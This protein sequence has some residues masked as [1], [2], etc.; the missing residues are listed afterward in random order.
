MPPRDTNK[1][2]KFLAKIPTFEPTSSNKQQSTDYETLSWIERG[3]E[4]YL[5]NKSRAF[6]TL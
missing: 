5:E 3:F 2:G 1:L 4:D 6:E